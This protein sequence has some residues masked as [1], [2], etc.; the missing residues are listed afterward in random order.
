MTRIG[1]LSCAAIARPGAER[2]VSV[3]LPLI[4]RRRLRSVMLLSCYCGFT[5]NTSPS[6]AGK[7]NLLPSTSTM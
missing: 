6:V 1:S 4:R 7:G 3:L 5:S 2:L